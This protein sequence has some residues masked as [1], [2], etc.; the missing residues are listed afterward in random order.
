MHMLLCY[1]CFTHSVPFIIPKCKLKS[2][3]NTLWKGYHIGLPKLKGGFNGLRHLCDSQIIPLQIPIALNQTR[4]GWSSRR[5]AISNK[6]FLYKY[7]IARKVDNNATFTKGLPTKITFG[8]CMARAM[9]VLCQGF[10][11]I[12]DIRIH[13]VIWIINNNVATEITCLQK[14]MVTLKNVT[15]SE[16]L[17]LLC[18]PLTVSSHP[19]LLKSSL[20]SHI[21]F[22]LLSFAR[23]RVHFVQHIYWCVCLRM[24]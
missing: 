24:L 16:N 19:Q 12:K 9:I 21:F 1:H 20:Q 14:D 10:C 13:I 11:Y 8:D 23:E 5:G 18:P 22:S 7:W 17:A 3:K 15:P 6:Q 4:G 2:A